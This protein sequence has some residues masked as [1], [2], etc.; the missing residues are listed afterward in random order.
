M[1]PFVFRHFRSTLVGAH[2]LHLFLGVSIGCAILGLSW[3]R[4]CHEL[5]DHGHRRLLTCRV[6]NGEGWG[7]G[8]D[9]MDKN[10]PRSLAGSPKPIHGLKNMAKLVPSLSEAL[11]SWW[12]LVAPLL[13][14][15]R[16]RRERCAALA[17]L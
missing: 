10:G 5:A 17:R 11:H 14:A 12:V 8:G 9:E 2:S 16:G 15:A 7:G 6:G 4:C 13:A 3:P 1:V